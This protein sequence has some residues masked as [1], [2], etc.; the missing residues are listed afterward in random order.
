MAW[1]DPNSWSKTDSELASMLPVFYSKRIREIID[2]DE[3]LWQTIETDPLAERSGLVAT[4]MQYALMEPQAASTVLTEGA[5]PNPTDLVTG[6]I[7]CTVVEKGAV[8][9]IPSLARLSIAD[10]AEKVATVVGAHGSQSMERHTA[11]TLA[12]Y[13]QQLRVDADATYEENSST[14][15]DGSTT[16]LNDTGAGW[17]TNSMAGGLL[18]IIDPYVGTFGESQ[19][20]ASNVANT[21]ITVGTAF[22]AAI[23][24]GTDYHVSIPTGIVATDKLTLTGI[25]LAQKQLR[26]I[27]IKGPLWEIDGGGY[28]IVL[29][30]VTEADIQTDLISAFQYKPN[31]AVQRKYPDRGMIAMCR[32]TITSIPFRSAVTGNGTYAAGGICH[33]TPVIGKNCLSKLP[34]GQMDIKVTS[35]AEDSGGTSN[36]LNR[37]STTGWEFKGAF[38]K[39]NLAAGCAII[40]GEN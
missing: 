6:K 29:D 8:V 21:S 36:P 20:V 5:N 33:Y 12:C 13:L 30:A 37:F 40:S 1:A 26:K 23:L 28:N 19:F 10:G 24:S 2:H 9:A 14:T 39:R 31:E 15:S 38:L 16:L 18:T 34:L 35:K 7:T 11:E 3:G 25:R 32:P 22:S 17:T 4:F 27:G